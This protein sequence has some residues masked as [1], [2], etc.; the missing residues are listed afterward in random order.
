[1]KLRNLISLIFIKSSLAS[2]TDDSICPLFFVDNSDQLFK[3]L[4]NTSSN[5]LLKKNSMTRILE[6]VATILKSY[7]KV[8]RTVILLLETHQNTE[9]KSIPGKSENKYPGAS[10]F[11]EFM[12]KTPVFYLMDGRA[13]INL[14]FLFFILFEARQRSLINQNEFLPFSEFATKFQSQISNF[15]K[16][17][18]LLDLEMIF[19]HISKAITSILNDIGAKDISKSEDVEFLKSYF[20]Q[21]SKNLHFPNLKSYL[22][23]LE[24]QFCDF[25]RYVSGMKVEVAD[26][27]QISIQ[28]FHISENYR[29]LKGII[30]FI[31]EM[32]FSYKKNSEKIIELDQESNKRLVD[33]GVMIL[34]YSL[35]KPINYTTV[36]SSFQSKVFGS[37]FGIFDINP[38]DPQLL[39]KFPIKS[40]IVCHICESNKEQEVACILDENPDKNQNEEYSSKTMTGL[41]NLETI[42]SLQDLETSFKILLALIDEFS[43]NYKPDEITKG[44]SDSDRIP[45]FLF[46]RLKKDIIHP[47]FDKNLSD[48]QIVMKEIMKIIHDLNYEKNLKIKKKI[49]NMFLLLDISACI[50][51]ILFGMALYQKLK[52]L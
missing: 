6:S 10:L 12:R 1:M 2:I 45:L 32:K 24:K 36:E 44:A 43:L 19:D 27:T 23:L 14:D 17:D 35:T 49:A 42:T 30:E 15:I 7:D 11:F 51:A 5:I 9:Y 33:L 3:I 47:N 13:N 46:L 4:E 41:E 26:E 21:K 52:S 8:K 29:I 16:K 18:L 39:D 25:E 31:V 48:C 34:L 40:N 20:S 37:K 38:T 28:I 50:L 22:A